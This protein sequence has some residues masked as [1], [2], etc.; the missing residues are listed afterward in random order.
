MDRT[1]RHTNSACRVELFHYI[2]TD[3][4]EEI[5]TLGTA[6]HDALMNVKKETIIDSLQQVTINKSMD[7]VRGT[8]DILLLPTHNWKK[9]VRPGDW[10]V[11]YMGIDENEE[12]RLLGNVDRVSRIVQTDATG[13][14]TTRYKISGS[15]FGKVFEANVHY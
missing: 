3:L 12:P 9:R 1:I 4:V 6:G 7:A 10:L 5:S 2:T 8:F 13:I 14:K 11:I 15:N